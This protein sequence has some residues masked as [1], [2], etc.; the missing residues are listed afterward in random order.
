M[1]RIDPSTIVYWAYVG[2][3]EKKMETTLWYLKTLVLASTFSAKNRVKAPRTT[4]DPDPR[5]Q[6]PPQTATSTKAKLLNR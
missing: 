2:M 3:V 6:S 1:F 4:R 5:G